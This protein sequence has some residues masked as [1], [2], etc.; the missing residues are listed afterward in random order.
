MKEGRYYEKLNG[1]RLQCR[2]CPH[3]CKINKEN[4]GKCGV[5][6]NK[7]G[8]LISLNYGKIS[9]LHLDPIEKKPIHFY[10]EGTQT[11]SVGS[12]GCNFRCPFCQNHIIAKSI[13]PTRRMSPK[14]IVEEAVRKGVP[15]ISYT[16]N[17]PT[18]FYEMVLETAKLG[19]KRGL[20]NILVTNGYIE[21]EPLEELIPFIDGANVDL[22]GFNP[23]IY[24]EVFGGDL[25][26]VKRNIAY[27]Q[28]NLHLEIT[29]LVVTGINDRKEELTGLFH[30]LASISPEIPLHLN[31]Y[32]P[33]YQYHA[34]PT[35]IDFLLEMKG[36]AEKV[37]N[38][39]R[40]GNF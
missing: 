36:E 33:S 9:G 2:L 38:R 34:D 29:T 22:K 27:F 40:C 35:D 3:L 7:N 15:S 13:P 1:G 12:F 25:D 37:L 5:R 18:V 26:V 20:K 39:V 28:Q 4:V 23:Q 16:Y 32:Y 19:K 6:K 17:E 21:K 10:L 30:W 8:E 14:E 31:R 11:L 24:Q